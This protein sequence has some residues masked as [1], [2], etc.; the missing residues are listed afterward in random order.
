MLLFAVYSDYDL[1][2]LYKYFMLAWKLI[3]IIINFSGKLIFSIKMRMM[4]GCETPICC[5]VDWQLSV[6]GLIDF[7]PYPI[8]VWMNFDTIKQKFNFGFTMKYIDAWTII[9]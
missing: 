9:N 7:K 5:A 6:A 4:D 2:K 8:S 3:D 1:I